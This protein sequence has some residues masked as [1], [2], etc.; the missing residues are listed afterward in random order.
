MKDVMIDL[1]TFGNGS[2][3]CIIQIGGAYFNRVTGEIGETFKRNVDARTSE[4]EGARLDADTFDFVIVSGVMKKLNI[5]PKFSFRTARDIRTLLDVSKVDY[6]SFTRHGT[7]HD[8]LDDAIFQIQY[9]VAA[10]VRIP[11]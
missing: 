4:R 2:D 6:K 10:L 7:H 11:L 1:E 9:C 8:A 5:K 3:A